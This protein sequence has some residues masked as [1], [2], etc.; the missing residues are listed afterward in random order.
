MFVERGRKNMINKNDFIK[1][2]GG[3]GCYDFKLCKNGSFLWSKSFC[4]KNKIM[5]MKSYDIYSHKNNSN[6][7]LFE[8]HTGLGGHYKISVRDTGSMQG[9]VLNFVKNNPL[10]LGCYNLKEKQEDGS[11]LLMLF[12]RIKDENG[13]RNQ[14]EGGTRYKESSRR[15]F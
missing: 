2:K 15:P 4:A 5:G 7:I 14:A 11:L 6:V 1:T 13:K 10:L 8:L 9:T 12:E 3:R